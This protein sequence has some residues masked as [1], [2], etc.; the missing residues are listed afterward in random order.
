TVTALAPAATIP[1][2]Y[3]PPSPL[4]RHTGSPALRRSTVT[5]WRAASLS[6]LISAPAVTG[7]GVNIRVVRMGSPCRGNLIGLY[8]TAAAR[9]VSSGESARRR[10]LAPRQK[11]LRLAVV[12]CEGLLSVTCGHQSK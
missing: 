7:V 6:R 9:V 10:L 12:T 5:R 3:S 4:N 1:P 2:P 11:F 8:C